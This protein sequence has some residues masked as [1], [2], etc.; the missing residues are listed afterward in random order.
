[1]LLTRPTWPLA[2]S[3]A[4]KPVNSVET[5]VFAVEQGPGN[6]GVHSTY[7]LLRQELRDG[8]HSFS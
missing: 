5:T 4:V 6:I 8:G 7:V 2:P 3:A 1:M